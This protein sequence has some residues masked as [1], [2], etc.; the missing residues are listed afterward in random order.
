MF[1]AQ[2]RLPTG[3][4]MEKT[5]GSVLVQ[6]P[7]EPEAQEGMR[8][9]LVTL[10]F[11]PASVPSELLVIVKV[12]LNVWPTFPVALKFGPAEPKTPAKTGMAAQK[13]SAARAARI[14]HKRTRNKTPFILP[15]A[16]S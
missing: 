12:P 15:I 4:A 14:L 9:M 10:I 16:I 7:P 6:I 2:A 11:A 13:M 8:I 5:P 1:P 3:F